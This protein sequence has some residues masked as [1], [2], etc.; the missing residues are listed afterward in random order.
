MTK[1]E[2]LNLLLGEAMKKITLSPPLAVM[3]KNLCQGYLCKQSDEQVDVL[4]EYFLKLA[5]WLNEVDGDEQES[6]DN[7]GK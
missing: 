6:E 1:R 7:P 5:K 3:L 4:C 2:K